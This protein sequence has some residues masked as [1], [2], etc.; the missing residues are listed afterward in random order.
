MTLLELHYVTGIMLTELCYLCQ[1]NYVALTE[2]Y[3]ITGITL[4]FEKCIMLI[5]LC[6]INENKLHWVNG[7]TLPE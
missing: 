3:Y 7:I 6:Y 5:G 2:L 4:Y 1:W